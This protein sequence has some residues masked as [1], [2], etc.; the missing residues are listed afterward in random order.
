MFW[1]L[2]LLS[3]VA[4]SA[5]VFSDD[6]VRVLCA[7]YP[8][9]SLLV[10]SA[11]STRATDKAMALNVSDRT[12]VRIWFLGGLIVVVSTSCLIAPGMAYKLD[13]V[14]GRSLRSVQTNSGEDVFL[15]SRY[16]SGFL[17]IP[18]GALL[19]RDFPSIP[20][21]MFRKIIANSGIEQYERLSL[22]AD[23]ITPFGVVVAPGLFANGGAL[24][25]L[26]QDV[27]LDRKA[28]GWK[29]TLSAGAYWHRVEN[30]VPIYI[31]PT[32]A[33]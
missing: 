2:F 29:M 15:A 3:L 11:F 26:P 19:R 30:A 31:N 13:A 17:V 25:I 28:T 20:L 32:K 8:I 33:E 27:L 23:P 14:N 1:G 22:P 18:E 16:M 4:S 21:K 5:I 24:L 10:A 12:A 9:L 6:G 7:S